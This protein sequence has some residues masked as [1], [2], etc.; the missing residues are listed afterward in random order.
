VKEMSL[1]TLRAR[2]EYAGG[3]TLG[4]I[5]QQKLRSFYAA[6]ENDYNSRPILTPIG[7]EFQALINDNNTKPDYDKRFVSVD[8]EA[9][10]SP[11]DVFE[12]T[13]DN[14]Y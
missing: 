7:E 12:C 2:I 4:R 9:G 5:K 10:L 3:D 11:G 6:L 14:T 1:E 8:F 13:D